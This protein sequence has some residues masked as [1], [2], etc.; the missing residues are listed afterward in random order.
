MVAQAAGKIS[1]MPGCGLTADNVVEVM[2]VTGAQEVHAACS[3]R[4]PGDPAFSD[5]DPPGGRFVTSEMQVRE[6]ATRI[7]G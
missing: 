1:I 6:M 3:V 5:F 2:A 7:N 4:V